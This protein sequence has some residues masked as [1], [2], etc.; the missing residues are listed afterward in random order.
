MSFPKL[1]AVLAKESRH[2]LRDPATLILLLLVPVMLMIIM[3]YALVADIRQTPITVIDYSHSA[4]SRR[5]LAILASS[6]DI[7]IDRIANSYAEAEQYFNRNQ[8]KALIVIPPEFANRLTAGKSAEL[9]IIVDGTDPTTANHVINHVVS[10]SQAFGWEQAAKTPGQIRPPGEAKM[11]GIAAPAIDLRTRVWYNPNLKNTHGI[12][13]A[14]MPIV[15]SMSA[16]VVMNAIVREK[17]YGTLETIFATPLGRGELLVGKLI[18]YVLAGLISAVLCALVAVNLFGVP[19]EGA[20]SLFLLLTVDFLLAA[21]A[22]GI[23]LVTFITSQTA[24]SMLGLL[25]FIFPGFFLSGIFYPVSSFPDLVKEEAQWLPS[26]H[27]V[28]IVRGIMIKGQGLEALWQPALMLLGLALMMTAL[29][30]F[31]FKKKLR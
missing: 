7:V 12:I 8:T 15:L 18:P 31:L 6:E 21:F 26:T 19:F 30:V 10:R 9:Q 16:I 28:T 2:I 17:E 1:W 25:F 23:F 11:M 13:P 27:F 14:L 4:L 5:F 20:F 29:S 22:M 3:S 24:A